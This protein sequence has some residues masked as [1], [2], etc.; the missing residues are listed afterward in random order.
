[1]HCWIFRIQ[2]ISRPSSETGNERKIILLFWS[3]TCN[4]ELIE[5]FLDPLL[6]VEMKA[7]IR[8]HLVTQVHKIFILLRR[9][10]HRRYCYDVGRVS[11]A[12]ALRGVDNQLYLEQGTI[13][14]GEFW[15]ITSSIVTRTTTSRR[16]NRRIAQAQIA[17]RTTTGELPTRSTSTG[18][19]QDHTHW[20]KEKPSEK[21]RIP[22]SR[23]TECGNKW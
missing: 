3:L 8:K 5:W 19:W 9:M 15:R 7:W 6:K 4:N 1:M 11:A 22:G 16:G 17:H 21:W 20:W 10:C 12:W 14:S 18:R 13:L 2:I 23:T